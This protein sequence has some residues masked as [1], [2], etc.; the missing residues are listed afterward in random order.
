VVIAHRPLQNTEIT[1][2]QKVDILNGSQTDALQTKKQP[3]Q[4]GAL[5]RRLPDGAGR[6]ELAPIGGSVT[7]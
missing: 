2:V 1:R 3:L 4:K 7:A 6:R 5:P